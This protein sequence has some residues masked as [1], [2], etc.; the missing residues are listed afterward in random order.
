MKSRLRSTRNPF[1]P[2]V[3]TLTGLALLTSHS[4]Q[5]A[6]GSW[7]GTA[8]GPFNWSDTTQWNAGTVADGAG[9]SAA[10][11][12][13]VLVAVTP[14]NV[15]TTLDT[16]RTI[17]SIS[18]GGSLVSGTH[19]STQANWTITSASNALTLDNGASN[20]NF[21]ITVNGITIMTVDTDLVLNSNLVLSANGNANNQVVLGSAVGGHTITGS[22]NITLNNTTQNGAGRLTINDNI[23]TTGGLFNISAPNN[24]QPL[25]IAG[26]IGSTVTGVTQSGTV[27]MSLTGANT[28]TSATNVTGASLILSGA[29]GSIALSSALNLN[30]G[31]LFL[32]NSGT[33]NPDRITSAVNMSLGGELSL[34]GNSAANPAETFGAL[35]FG[36]GNAT[37][38]TTSFT[39]Q[40]ATLSAASFARTAGAFGTAFVRGSSLGGAGSSFIG[41]IALG[42]TPSGADLVG[43]G[44]APAGSTTTKNLGIVPWMIGA[45]TPT[46]TAGTGFVTYDTTSGS[47]RPLA[48][49]EYETNTLTLAT[50][51]N[52]VKEPIDC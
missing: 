43:S 20:V 51:G 46:L 32:D 27:N 5:A 18:R 36:Q 19:N 28:Y 14:T 8:A 25:T 6:A 30:G 52:N 33:N 45:T 17:G 4:A 35:T 12:N 34:T 15:T 9:F 38:T 40:T 23:N 7:T 48:S 47:L 24:T 26:I 29:S 13:L 50:A 41:K 49:G 42:A 16:A 37:L 39:S 2:T 10:F 22:G 44:G 11:N 3:M 31:R 1:F 21:F